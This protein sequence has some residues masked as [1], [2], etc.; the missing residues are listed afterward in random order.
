MGSAGLT[1]LG[2]GKG[3]VWLMWSR[4]TLGPVIGLNAVAQTCFPRNR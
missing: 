1:H 4:H 2:K 3:P